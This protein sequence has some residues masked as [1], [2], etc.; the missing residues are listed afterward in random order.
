MKTIHQ[1]IKA[2]GEQTHAAHEANF[3]PREIARAQ[4]VLR[5]LLA[6]HEDICH[7]QD[8]GIYEVTIRSQTREVT[9]RVDEEAAHQVAEDLYTLVGKRC[10]QQSTVIVRTHEALHKDG[11]SLR[12][13]QMLNLLL[14]PVGH[15]GLPMTE[16][17]MRPLIPAEDALAEPK[18]RRRA[19]AADQI[20]EGR[21]R[22]S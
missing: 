14:T 4:Q 21:Q 12:R 10:D 18:S 8:E 20:P 3:F 13:I 19:T 1:Q 11:E 15:T 7:A 9:V 22:I 5:M 16:A 6:L 17:V 2:L